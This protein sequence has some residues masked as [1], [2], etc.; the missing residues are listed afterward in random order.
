MNSTS[1]NTK[2]DMLYFKR[3]G[4]NCFGMKEGMD[5][6]ER[7]GAGEYKQNSLHSNLEKLK[8]QEN[9]DKI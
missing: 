1:S 3:G 7:E 5:L 8:V 2:L 4:A 6:A 9:I